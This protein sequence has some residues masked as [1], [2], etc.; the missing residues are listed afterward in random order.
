[1]ANATPHGTGATGASGGATAGSVSPA[2]STVVGLL[3]EFLGL[4]LLTL[5]AG[6]SD[7]AGTVVILMMTGFWI[8]YLVTN[9]G[10]VQGF[11]QKISTLSKQ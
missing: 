6:S 3:L 11:S 7:Q 5:L 1:V 2:H 9:A 10:V 8:I 4:G